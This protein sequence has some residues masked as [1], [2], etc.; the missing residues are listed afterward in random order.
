MLLITTFTFI[1]A[2]PSSAI[3]G[4]SGC[5]K[6]R[7]EILTEERLGL[8]YFKDFNNQRKKL[9]MMASPRRSDLANVLSW[10]TNVSNSDQIVFAIVEKNQKCFSAKDVIRAREWSVDTRESASMSSYL[11][12]MYANKSDLL[13]PAEVNDLKRNYSG[14]YSFLNP[15]KKIA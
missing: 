5:E 13:T 11:A 6:V 12:V 9:L 3:L 7:K 10:V 15:K 8:I 2:V 4:L 14:F 1:Q